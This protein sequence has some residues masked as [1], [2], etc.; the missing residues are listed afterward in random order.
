[1]IL[2]VTKSLETMLRDSTLSLL[3]IAKMVIILDSLDKPKILFSL[4]LRQS[5]SITLDF[6]IL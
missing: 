3:F 1:M 5:L 2:T 4:F 6:V